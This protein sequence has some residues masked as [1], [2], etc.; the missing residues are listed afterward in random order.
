M[1]TVTLSYRRV[2]NMLSTGS[3]TSDDGLNF[4]SD[5]DFLALEFRAMMTLLSHSLGER[6][7]PELDLK[8]VI[9]RT[10]REGLQPYPLDPRVVT[11]L[12]TD[13]KA[14]IAA[15]EYPTGSPSKAIQRVQEERAPK[16]RVPIIVG[17]DALADA[18]G[19]QVYFRV[20][21]HELECPGCGY[22]GMFSSPRLLED[23]ERAGDVFK[24]MFVCP[25]RCG[26]R[27]PVTCQEKWGYADVSYLLEMTKLDRFYFPRAWNEGRPWVSR[28][29]LKKKYDEYKTEKEAVTCSVTE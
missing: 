23:S 20:K 15:L 12:R 21:H 22:W 5:G 29:F 7:H 8:V 18:F 26:V 1:P 24:T 25:K 10:D 28:E 13:V 27:I 14:A 11:L 16:A 2:G 17:Y 3:I 6:W 4:Q 19:D 9:Q